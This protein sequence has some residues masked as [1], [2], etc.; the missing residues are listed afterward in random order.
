MP[1]FEV[2]PYAAARF[3]SSAGSPLATRSAA[4]R[5]AIACVVVTADQVQRGKPAPDPYLLA[6]ARLGVPAEEC[7]V[8]EDAPSGVTAGVAA[9]MTAWAVTTTHAIA[10]LGAAD[11]VASGLPELLAELST[12]RAA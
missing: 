12:R 10:D 11:R 2:R 8:L 5:S 6:A 1:Q 4:P 7:L 9:G 3:A